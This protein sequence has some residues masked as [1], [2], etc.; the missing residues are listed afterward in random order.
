VTRRFT[1]VTVVL[2]SALAFLLGLV[3]AGPAR[4]WAS[5]RAPATSPPSLG[6][7]SWP[8]RSAVPLS[9]ADVAARV[10]PAV[11]Y[12]E[13]ATPVPPERQDGDRGSK[14]ARPPAERDDTS[15]QA[16]RDSGS[17]FLL[18]ADGEILTNHHLVEGAERLVVTLA[19]GRSMRARVLGT[20]PDMDLALL[21][22]DG[23][24][25]LPTV[26]LGDSGS[27]RPGEWV[28]AIG[29]PLGYEHT[30][31]VGVVSYLGR[32][33]F[34]EGL[35]DYIQT[36]AAI[37][38]GN[39]GGPLIDASG[40][41]VGINTAVSAEGEHIGFAVPI[42]QARDVLDQL[43]QRGRAVRGYIGVSL[44]DLDTDL[45]HALRLGA[46]EGVLV[47]DVSSDSPGERA[48]LR[49]Y[50]V[51]ASVEGRGVRTASAVT[52]DIAARLPGTPVRLQVVRDGRGQ[53]LTVQLA[54]RPLR[55][56]GPAATPGGRA[57][58]HVPERTG[59]GLAVED[60]PAAPGRW[61][62]PPGLSGAFVARVVPLS[63]ADDAEMQRGDVILE[64]NRVPVRSAAQFR[65]IASSS[66]P[67]DALTFY[68]Y[69]PRSGQRFIRTLR[70]A[71]R[72]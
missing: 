53:D 43:R 66:S 39:S 57:A 13:A 4:P 58:G 50:D 12:L 48:G 41:V 54:E 49:R 52:R 22:I 64:V 65:Q 8:Q 14:R 72:Q 20:D 37:D 11:V 1:L 27:L 40:K 18:S 16:D 69:D 31:T 10:N 61:R 5:T 29:N 47:E 6:H 71:P 19:D 56:P 24:A 38:L 60:L 46:V 36:D 17:G 55:E 34:D 35:D 21:K 3:S 67:G 25:G 42:N 26:E 63:P 51:I 2:A 59:I 28:C 45:R 62:L 33:L 68:L 30:V 70:V 7:A 32:K 44:H 15:D 23:V 9:F